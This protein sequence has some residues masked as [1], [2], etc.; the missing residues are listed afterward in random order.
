MSENQVEK[1]KFNFEEML[2]EAINRNRRIKL[3]PHLQNQLLNLQ[4]SAWESDADFYNSDEGHIY[5]SNE[6]EMEPENLENDLY[7]QSELGAGGQDDELEVQMGE[8]IGKIEGY[9]VDNFDKRQNP[10][11]F[12][13]ANELMSCFYKFKATGKPDGGF[14][15][16]I[17]QLYRNIKNNK[18]DTLANQF[19]TDSIFD[20][21]EQLNQM[22]GQVGQNT[23]ISNP[24]SMGF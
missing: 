7:G 10:E 4:E 6:F 20:N 17:L 18:A 21:L 24:F 12:K 11:L 5:N 13:A 19:N 14:G 3:S 9:C 15:T 23:M 22:I 16:A 2:E 1:R 8:L